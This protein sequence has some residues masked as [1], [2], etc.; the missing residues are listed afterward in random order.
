MEIRLSS[1]GVEGERRRMEEFVRI[2]RERKIAVNQSIY[3]ICKW[4]RL[5]SSRLACSV[6]FA[7]LPFAFGLRFCSFLVAWMAGSC[8]LNL[9]SSCYFGW[10]WCW[11]ASLESLALCSSSLF[12]PLI[13]AFS[14]VSLSCSLHFVEVLVHFGL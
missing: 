1:G 6:V 13:V 5:S 11:F 2:W 3:I 4:I 9:F 12:L 10:L 7:A 8:V 14:C